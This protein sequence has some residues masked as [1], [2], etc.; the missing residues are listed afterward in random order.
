MDTMTHTHP[1]AMWRTGAARL[2]SRVHSCST[3]FGNGYAMKPANVTAIFGTLEP[4]RRG[5]PPQ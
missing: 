4:T 3:V 2:R 1:N 5:V